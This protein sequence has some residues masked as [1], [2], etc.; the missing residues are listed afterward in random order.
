MFDFEN[1]HFCREGCWKTIQFLTVFT[2][3]S[4]VKPNL[5]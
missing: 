3:F 1:S 4:I 5:E 2:E